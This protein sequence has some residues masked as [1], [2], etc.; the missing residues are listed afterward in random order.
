MFVGVSV[1]CVCVYVSVCACLYA[2][3]CE[4]MCV[5]F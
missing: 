4:L 5:C 2:C 1:C 3:V